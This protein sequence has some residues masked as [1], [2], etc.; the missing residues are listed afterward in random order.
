MKRLRFTIALFCAATCLVASTEIDSLIEAGK[1]NDPIA[2]RSFLERK[3]NVTETAPD[4]TTAL[5]WAAH[6]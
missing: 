5:H 6:W 1:R 3:A 4:G 2:V